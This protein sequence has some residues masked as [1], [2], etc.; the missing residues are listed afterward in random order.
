MTDPALIL[1]TEARYDSDTTCAKILHMDATVIPRLLVAL[2]ALISL[3]Y[4]QQTAHNAVRKVL[5]NNPGTTDAETVIKLS[6]K[7][8]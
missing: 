8:L 2:L 1:Y 5:E 4:N 6:L 3:G 7:Y